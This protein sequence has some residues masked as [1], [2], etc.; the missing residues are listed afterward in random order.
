VSNIVNRICDTLHHLLESVEVDP[1]P[2]LTVAYSGGVDSTLL[3]HAL[4]HYRDRHDLDVHAVHVHHGL[5]DNADSWLA[6]C[7]RECRFLDIPF[8]A[9]KVDIEQTTR[10][11]LEALARNARYAALHD[12]CKQ[13]NSILCLGQHSEDQLETVLLQL[14][15]GAGPQG[16]AG[17][18]AFQWRNKVLTLRPML[19]ESKQDILSAAQQLNLNW[20]E[21][22][23]N[24]D[25]R[26][27]R[28]FLRNEVLP[29]LTARWPQMAKTTGRSAALCAEQSALL[30]TEAKTHLSRC[31][32]V[33]AFGTSMLSGKY[34]LSLSDSWK[35]AVIRQWFASK[36]ALAPSQAQ[37]V[38]VLNM[39]N[40]R[41]DATP[42]V[43]FSWGYVAR[44]QGS[45]YW[46]NNADERVKRELTLPEGSTLTLAWLN[47]QLR[48]ESNFEEEKPLQLVVKTDVKG[49]KIKPAN[50][51]VSKPLKDWYKYW[52]IPVWE[53]AKIPVVFFKED[54]IALL[55]N[56]DVVRLH[57]CPASFQLTVVSS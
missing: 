50:A 55:I 27:D 11:S 3:L 51:Q 56:G 26:F 17:M 48:F 9:N 6:H 35:R 33:S 39:L 54:A 34:I 24:A 41:E 45:L 42:K 1:S 44:Y 14:K 37:L 25:T 36:G 57:R 21:D 32:S 16:L 28:N 38:Q 47:L 18:G 2:I 10:T 40:A 15:R 22:E 12:Y 43:T 8:T 7:E 5:S 31:E 52:K 13:H 19:Q 53:R 4:A 23:S 30:E 20:V 49:L 46:V 29:L